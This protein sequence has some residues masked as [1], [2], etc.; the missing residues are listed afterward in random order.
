MLDDYYVYVMRSDNGNILNEKRYLLPPTPIS[1]FFFRQGS[2][3][4]YIKCNLSPYQSS[5]IEGEHFV[6]AQVVF[7]GTQ[8]PFSYDKD[9][10]RTYSKAEELQYGNCIPGVDGLELKI[11]ILSDIDITGDETSPVLKRD[12]Q[13]NVILAKPE[14]VVEVV[15]ET[16]KVINRKIKVTPDYGYETRKWVKPT[17]RL[18]KSEKRSDDNSLVYLAGFETQVVK[19]GEIIVVLSHKNPDNIAKYHILNKSSNLYFQG[20]LPK[21]H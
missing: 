3:D 5:L 6:Q 9:G 18:I 10:R 14:E 7:V 11:D 4:G 20:S 17:L 1:E 13:G 21:N 19:P 8:N 16:G 2:D 15:D 12:A